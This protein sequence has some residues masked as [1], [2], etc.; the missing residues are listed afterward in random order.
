MPV[1]FASIFCP[2][3]P[4][5]TGRNLALIGPSHYCSRVWLCG[6]LDILV[7]F[8]QNLAELPSKLPLQLKASTRLR[9]LETCFSQRR[10]AGLLEVGRTNWVRNSSR[11]REML[12]SIGVGWRLSRPERDRYR[13]R[14]ALCR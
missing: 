10:S 7:P 3:C 14:F 2:V 8:R 4:A 11:N 9:L 6:G 13:G 12:W 1:S 5:A